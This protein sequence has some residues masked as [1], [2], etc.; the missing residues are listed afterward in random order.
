MSG[1]AVR[2]T[3]NAPLRCTSITASSDSGVTFL[4]AASRRM[5][6]LFTTMSTRPNV[7]SAHCTM[8]APPVGGGHGV[9]VAHRLAARGADLGDDLLGR[10]RRAAGAVDRAAE[11]V[12]HDQR[13]PPGELECV[14]A[15][16]TAAGPGDDRDLSVEGEWVHGDGD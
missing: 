14:A 16:E 13:A 15:A 11:V 4:N 9:G 6:A 12:H 7:S 5:P 3:L 8:A 10:G 1:H 2:S